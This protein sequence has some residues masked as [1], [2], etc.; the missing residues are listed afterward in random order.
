MPVKRGR[1]RPR[2]IEINP[3]AELI[4]HKPEARPRQPR[5]NPPPTAKPFD[6]PLE[7][8]DMPLPTAIVTT[9]ASIIPSIFGPDS[10]FTDEEKTILIDVWARYFRSINAVLSP[11]WTAVGVSAAIAIPKMATPSAREKIGKLMG[12]KNHA[13][14]DNRPN[15]VG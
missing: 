3:A 4:E 12:H 8:Q 1:G 5:K 11:L 14:T 15:N 13:P 2:K 10:A 9:A 7:P 6:A